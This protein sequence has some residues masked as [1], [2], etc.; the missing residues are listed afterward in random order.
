MFHTAANSITLTTKATERMKHIHWDAKSEARSWGGKTTLRY[1][2]NNLIEIGKMHWD[3]VAVWEDENSG[4]NTDGKFG[5]NLFKGYV[6]EID[7]DKNLLILHQSL[8]D[9]ANGY[10]KMEMLS[11]N[12][13][14]F[15]QATSSIGGIDYKNQFLI[16][17]GYGGALLFDDRFSAES[18]IGERIEIIDEKEL[19]DSF[20]NVLKI[21]KGI[22]PML[23]IGDI[24]LKNVPVGFF[25]GKI[26]QQQ[27]SIIGGD[28]LKRFNIIIDSDSAFIYLK[29]NQL[30]NS[31]YTQF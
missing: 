13:N 15:I 16:H 10:L 5:P 17:S 12:Y 30:K 24:E 22:L 27:M 9:K 7:F 19:K 23:T 11:E 18:K 25:Q 8:P 28:I 6:I 31:A 20:G 29:S 4:P 21:K 1:S 14:P 3:S 26:G 2:E